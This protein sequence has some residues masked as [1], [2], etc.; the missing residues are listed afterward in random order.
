M[1]GAEIGSGCVALRS[2]D[3]VRKEIE[4]VRIKFSADSDFDLQADFVVSVPFNQPSGRVSMINMA[5]DTHR[6]S[7][8]VTSGG[9][10]HSVTYSLYQL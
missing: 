1:A 5:N 2:D 7:A 8:T 9:D 10:V 6:L 3:K 4:G